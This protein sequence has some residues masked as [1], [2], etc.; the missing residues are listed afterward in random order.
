MNS[1][2]GLSVQGKKK[3]CVL[4]TLHGSTLLRLLSLHPY[5][6]NVCP[7]EGFSSSMNS[8]SISAHFLAEHTSLDIIEHCMDCLI[9]FSHDI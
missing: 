8:E 2:K 3:L 6:D 5:S 1:K 9:N 7:A 4:R